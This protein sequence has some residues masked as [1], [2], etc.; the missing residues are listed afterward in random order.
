MPVGERVRL[1]FI[2]GA[3][4]DLVALLQNYC[5]QFA[6]GNGCFLML[7][8]ENLRQGKERYGDIPNGQNLFAG[9]RG[10]IAAPD[11]YRLFPYLLWNIITL[12][13]AREASF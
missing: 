5:R 3:G 7:K 4:N 11:F 13:H 1:R 9:N 6:A 8:P 2:N 12:H 10:N